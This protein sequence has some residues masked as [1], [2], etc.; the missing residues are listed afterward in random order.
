MEYNQL[1]KESGI[2]IVYSSCFCGEDINNKNYR[3]AILK[4]LIKNE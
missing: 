3:E 1:E 2:K 4:L